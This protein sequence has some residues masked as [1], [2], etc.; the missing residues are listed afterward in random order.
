MGT[1]TYIHPGGLPLRI[2]NCYPNISNVFTGSN[3]YYFMEELARQAQVEFVGWGYPNAFDKHEDGITPLWTQIVHEV[4]A[5]DGAIAMAG[6]RWQ[7]NAQQLRQAKSVLLYNLQRFFKDGDPAWVI[8]SRVTGRD[9][10]RDF[11][12]CRWVGDIH[13]SP[14]IQIKVA[15]QEL[16]LLLLRCLHSQYYFPTVKDFKAIFGIRPFTKWIE[17][18]HMIEVPDDWYISQLETK[19]AF[20]PPSFEPTYFKPVDESEKKYDVTMIATV[21][22]FYPLRQKIEKGLPTL[23]KEHGWNALL[24]RPPNMNDR[25]YRLQID[26]VL[27]DPEL[28]KRWFLGEDYARALAESKIF[29]FGSSLFRYASPKYFEAMGAGALVMADECH[30]AEDLHFKDGWNYVEITQDNWQEKLEYYL[31][32]D[33][34][35][36]TVARRGYENAMKYHS[37]QARAAELINHLKEA[38]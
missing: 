23:A 38:S 28:R 19:Y 18:G 2:L 4:K 29:I 35:R 8:G 11:K 5:V 7:L 30:H 16:D 10:N 34:L 36:E 25:I 3:V 13:V 15:N 20:W 14:D 1:S 31:E 17:S 27:K 22:G 9:V 24:R 21:G 32:D 6:G 33:Q 37:N 12:L 26:H